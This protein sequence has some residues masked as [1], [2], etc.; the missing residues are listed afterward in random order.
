MAEVVRVHAPGP[1]SAMRH[2]L[3]DVG[4]P[5]IGEVRLSQVAI[6]VN[7]IDRL[8]RDGRYPLPMPLVLGFE[9]AGV[10]EAIG[11]DTPGF[12]LGDRVAYFFSAGA[13]ATQRLIEA[14]SLV[15]LPADI[16]LEQ[17]AAF[18]AKGLTAWMAVRALRP[19][20]PGQSVL[21]L[22]ASGRVGSIIARWARALGVQV[23][24]VAG[25]ASAR[26]NAD[27]GCDVFL[28]TRDPNIAAKVRAWAPDGVDV[29]I[30]LVGRATAPL[31][32]ASVRDQGLILAIGAASGAP[33]GDDPLLARR[34]VTVRRAGAPDYFRTHNL[35]EAADDLFE[36][37]RQGVFADLAIA[38]YP[39]AEARRAHED[40][41]RSRIAGLP[42]LTV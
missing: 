39:F 8:S 5:C 3:V 10:V 37:L 30:D 31:A 13:Y 19:L 11:A 15:R 33:F 25:S 6:G 4:A 23:I 26:P 24:G 40:L 16:S 2:E 22:G 28:S 35:A 20:A 1:P 18:L 38:A 7:T 34:G 27:L 42:I 32:G 12:A 9:G 21:L 36:A 29:V 14:R 41:D 17:A